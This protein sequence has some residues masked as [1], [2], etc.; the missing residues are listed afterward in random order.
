MYLNCIENHSGIMPKRPIKCIVGPNEDKQ[1][2]NEKTKDCSVDVQNTD[3]TQ[4]TLC[5]ALLGTIMIGLC[6]GKSETYHGKTS[7][8]WW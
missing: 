7:E 2:F 8:K 4:K 3:S 1:V 6:K 5:L